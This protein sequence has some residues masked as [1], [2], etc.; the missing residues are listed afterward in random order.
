MVLF[1]TTGLT[2]WKSL[3]LDFRDHLLTRKQLRL[4]KQTQ[5]GIVLSGVSRYSKFL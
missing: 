1:H 5:N 3:P 2:F 4:Q